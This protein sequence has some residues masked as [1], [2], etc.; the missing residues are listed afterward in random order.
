MPASKTEYT[1]TD[2]TPMKPSA[3]QLQDSER[4][5]ITNAS[6]IAKQ[7]VNPAVN[8]NLL[9]PEQC[10]VL[11]LVKAGKSVFFTGSAGK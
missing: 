2:P 6:G 3:R 4:T 8:S 1:R 11:E 10:A 5:L 9:S 7:E